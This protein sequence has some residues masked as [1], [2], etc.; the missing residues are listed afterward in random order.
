MNK[1]LVVFLGI[2]VGGCVVTTENPV[3]PAADEK[4]DQRLLGAW[5]TE[6][7]ED[8][9]YI[10]IALGRE[11]K[12]INILTIEH[13]SSDRMQMERYLGHGSMV[14]D[15]GYLNLKQIEENTPQKHY[16]LVRYKFDERGHMLFSSMDEEATGKVVEAKEL[17]GKVNK[18][19]WVD[20]VHLTDTPEKLQ[21]LLNKRDAELFHNYVPLVRA[22]RAK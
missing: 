11:E 21:S 5:M 6:K 18:G 12:G 14:G 2:L 20:E 7:E 15:K 10:H 17:A 3:T 1:L 13:K 9:V 8:Q 4:I 22:V 16:L 19:K